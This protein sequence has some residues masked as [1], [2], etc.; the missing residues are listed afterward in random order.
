M[1]KKVKT[2]SF[3]AFLYPLETAISNNLLKYLS[4]IL[5][6]NDKMAIQIIESISFGREHSNESNKI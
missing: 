6:L 3:L 5:S 1:P 2:Y 4:K